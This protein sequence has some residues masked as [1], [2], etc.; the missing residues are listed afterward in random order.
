[1]RLYD[2]YFAWKNQWHRCRTQGR[3]FSW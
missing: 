3:H 2:R 1:V